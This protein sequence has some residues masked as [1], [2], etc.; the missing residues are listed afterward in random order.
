MDGARLDS[1]AKRLAGDIDRRRSLRAFA[2]FGLAGLAALDGQRAQGK[3][4][5]HGC[6]RKKRR[7]H[8]R[9]IDRDACCTDAE[10]DTGVCQDGRCVVRLPGTCD[11]GGGTCP[12]GLNDCGS[13]HDGICYCVPVQ[14][15]GKP[16]APRCVKELGYCRSSC[17]RC[18]P[19]NDC[20]APEAG[21][22][23]CGDFALCVIPCGDPLPPIGNARGSDLHQVRLN[24]RSGA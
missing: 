12:T 11:I 7:C 17:S 18:L 8:G 21:E 9:C 24:G 13:D 1:L 15:A 16:A 20:M 19:G 2:G 6:G 14:V 3:R 10:C 4:R 22:C 5:R 23:A